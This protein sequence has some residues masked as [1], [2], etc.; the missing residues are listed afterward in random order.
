MPFIAYWGAPIVDVDDEAVIDEAVSELMPR[1]ALPGGLDQE[2]A[3]GL[4]PM[5]GDGWMGRPG[6]LGHRRG[7]TAWAP[8]FKDA[9]VSPLGGGG[10]GC[11][12]TVRDDVAELELVLRVELCTSGALGLQATVRNLG[13]D[14]YSQRDAARQK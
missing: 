4:V 10:A 11:M 6:L 3:I 12:I 9:H 7:G 13:R 14:R 8:R 1:G 2:C 5:H